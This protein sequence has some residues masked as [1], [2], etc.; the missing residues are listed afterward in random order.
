MMADDNFHTHYPDQ[1][2]KNETAVPE[3]LQVF[4]GKTSVC[5][6]VLK[7]IFICGYLL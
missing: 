3:Q 6:Y 1:T 2:G 4:R 5:V 7:Q